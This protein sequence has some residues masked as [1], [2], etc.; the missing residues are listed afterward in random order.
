VGIKKEKK[1]KREK[2][3]KKISEAIYCV[4]VLPEF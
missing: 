2:E 1:K 3:K 4:R